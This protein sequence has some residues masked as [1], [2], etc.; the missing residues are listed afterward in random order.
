MT[1]CRKREPCDTTDTA[2]S[3]INRPFRSPSPAEQSSWGSCALRHHPWRS[4]RQH[5]VCACVWNAQ[6]TVHQ[7]L[8]GPRQ[9]ARPASRLMIPKYL[10]CISF[11]RRQKTQ[12]DN[13]PHRHVCSLPIRLTFPTTAIDDARECVCVRASHRET[14]NNVTYATAATAHS[15]LDI[16]AASSAVTATIHSATLPARARTT[17]RPSRLGTMANA[18]KGSVSVSGN[19][20][21]A[22][23]CCC[24]ATGLVLAAADVRETTT[25]SCSLARN[26][27][28]AG[29]IGVRLSIHVR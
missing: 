13:N 20:T 17:S 12:A 11:F 24:A 8:R 5:L 2:D 14:R 23:E 6:N 21:A 9:R 4:A 19:Q 10:S 25:R 7:E 29:S 1:T 28:S 3:T 27:V 26:R 16:N 18:T 22:A 15:C